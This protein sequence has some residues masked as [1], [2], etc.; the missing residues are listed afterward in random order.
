[1]LGR[2]GKRSKEWTNGRRKRGPSTSYKECFPYRQN[3]EPSSRK[4]NPFVLADLIHS[5]Q[6]GRRRHARR[7]V[8]W[9]GRGAEVDGRE[10]SG[11][12]LHRLYGQQLCRVSDDIGPSIMGLRPVQ[13]F[14]VRSDEIQMW[15]TLG[16][17]SAEEMFHSISGIKVL[18]IVCLLI[19][20][21]I[22]ALASCALSILMDFSEIQDKHGLF[23]ILL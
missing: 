3:L 2:K 20:Y 12:P 6:R 15:P 5:I 23:V 16:Q 21:Q 13:M 22:P 11:W 9:W 17:I 18:L 8:L 14:A 19:D 7:S 1:M 10:H 4:K